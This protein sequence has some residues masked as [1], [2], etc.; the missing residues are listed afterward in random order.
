[1]AGQCADD[2]HLSIMCCVRKPKTI[3]A[4]L[5]VVIIPIKDVKPDAVSLVEC[6]ERDVSWYVC[7]SNKRED[8]IE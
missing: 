8:A 1:M 3:G 4:S 7:T 5:R 2:T 6:D